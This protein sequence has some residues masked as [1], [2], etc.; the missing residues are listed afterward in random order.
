VIPYGILSPLTASDILNDTTLLSPIIKNGIWL[1]TDKITF[2]LNV[3][4]HDGHSARDSILVGFSRCACVLGYQVIEIS[5][6]DSIWLD[7]GTP[8]G[9]ISSYHWEPSNGLSNPDSS[10]T[11]C[12]PEVATNYFLARVDTFGCVCSCLAYEIRIN[13]TNAENIQIIP[14]GNINPFQKGRKVHFNNMR[15][16]EAL[17]YWYSMEGKLLYQCSTRSDNIDFPNVLLNRSTY[18]VKILLDEK[19]GICKFVNY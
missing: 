14:S 5:E 1:S 4:D 16:H 2:V 18:I 8:A 9:A 17:V 10:A 15:N 3:T 19:F 7:A 13:P 12:K 11:W 6:G